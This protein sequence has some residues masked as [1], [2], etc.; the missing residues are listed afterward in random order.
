MS[1]T[2]VKPLRI[3]EARRWIAGEL[4]ATWGGAGSARFSEVRPGI[5]ESDCPQRAGS[6]QPIQSNDGAPYS[7]GSRGVSGGRPPRQPD[8]LA[9]DPPFFASQRPHQA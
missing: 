7:M 3:G 4:S 1:Y 6:I 8:A 9:G 2:L 5:A